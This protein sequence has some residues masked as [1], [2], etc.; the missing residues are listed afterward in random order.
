MKNKEA[1][2]NVPS[3]EEAQAENNALP[4]TKE[5]AK[6]IEAF[7]RKK[8]SDLID[9]LYA[10][11]LASE[12]DDSEQDKKKIKD[13]SCSCGFVGAPLDDG[14]CPFCGNIG[15]V[16]PSNDISTPTKR[17][18]R[19]ESSKRLQ[20]DLAKYEQNKWLWI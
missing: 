8:A 20:E 4:D 12:E 16:E 18:S 14:R 19:L 3:K 6:F 17:Y 2:M 5:K 11:K 10:E 1:A 13:I 15:G 9:Q 7:H